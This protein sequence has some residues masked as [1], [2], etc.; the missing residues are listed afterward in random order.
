MNW[1]LVLI[2]FCLMAL[3]QTFL[4]L[5]PLWRLQRGIVRILEVGFLCGFVVAMVGSIPVL[6]EVET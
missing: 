6:W 4:N 2:G 3:T 1:V 5:L